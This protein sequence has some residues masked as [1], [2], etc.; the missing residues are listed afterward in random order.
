LIRRTNLE[1]VETE[2]M[3]EPRQINENVQP[4]AQLLGADITTLIC[5]FFTHELGVAR[6]NRHPYHY[7][8]KRQAVESLRGQRASS[9]DCTSIDR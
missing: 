3:I 9:I 4:N 8:Q 7:R 1:I 6:V 5:I 2:R